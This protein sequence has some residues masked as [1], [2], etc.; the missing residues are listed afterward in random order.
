VTPEE[1]T[2]RL[3]K[4]HAL[5]AEAIREDWAIFWA[6]RDARPPLPQPA[7]KPHEPWWDETSEG[8][9]AEALR[10]VRWRPVTGEPDPVARES[11]PHIPWPKGCRG[12]PR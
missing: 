8:E 2:E 11:L 3:D 9:V 6:L 1:V 10:A 12:E 5:M 4:I 7:P